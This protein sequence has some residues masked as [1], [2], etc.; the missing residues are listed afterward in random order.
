MIPVAAILTDPTHIFGYLIGVLALVFWLSTLKPLKSLFEFIPPVLWAYFVPM[1]STTVGITP[2]ESETYS[3]IKSV[4]LPFSLFLLMISVDMPAI[5][6]LGWRAMVMMLAGTAGIVIGGPIAYLLFGSFLEPEAWKE[7]A[8]LSGSWIGGTANMTAIAESVGTENL[9]SVIVVDTIV[10]YGWMAVLLFLSAYQKLFDNKYKADTTIL[11]DLDAKLSEMEDKRKPINTHAAAIIIG[12]GFVAAVAS[13]YIGGLLPNVGDPT[14]ISQATWAVLIVVTV[15]LALSFTPIRNLEQAG[16]SK[17]G[18]VALYLLLTAI[19]A[20]GDLKQVLEAPIFL[21]AGAV[22]ISIHIIVLFAVG[23][24]IR[25]P[26]FFIATGSMAN[27]GGAASA[28]IVAGVYS[29]AMAP[30]GLLM[31][32]AGYALGIY[33]GLACAWMLGQ[34]AM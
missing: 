30:V 32:V 12:L 29:P 25:A 26:L 27:V 7:F 19:G 18:Y 4:M 28:P 34:L 31:A 15:G 2:L 21:L 14:I 9:G 17:I 8:A 23:R 11:E 3:W 6:R 13:M 1:L 33:A 10:G 20:Q 16:A 5:L 22:W 24:I